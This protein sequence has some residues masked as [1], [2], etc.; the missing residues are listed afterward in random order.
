MQPAAQ[1]RRWRSRPP[2]GYVKPPDGSFT[3]AQLPFAD[4]TAGWYAYRRLDAPLRAFEARRG[5]WLLFSADYPSCRDGQKYFLLARRRMTTWMQ[6]FAAPQRQ[7]HEVIGGAARVDAFPRKVFVDYDA[8]SDGAAAVPFSDALCATLT[9]AQQ[10]WGEHAQHVVVF[11]AAR[12]PNFHAVFYRVFCTG[13]QGPASCE[14]A[15]T[16]LVA[17]MRRCGHAAAAA[18]VD[19][20]LAPKKSMRAPFACKRGGAEEL[21]LFDMPYVLPYLCG[22]KRSVEALQLGLVT[23][24]DG[25]TCRLADACHCSS[26]RVAPRG[27]GGCNASVSYARGN[28]PF[29]RVDAAIAAMLRQMT[30]PGRIRKVTCDGAI[31]TYWVTGNRFCAHVGRQHRSNHVLYVV[32]TAC[33]K[34][35]QRCLDPQCSGYASPPGDVVLG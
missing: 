30:P 32:N 2:P 7:L 14:T 4:G 12:S 33:L 13:M 23:Y 18:N 21:L 9:A 29:P 8:H 34:Y 22:R 17:Q 19:L 5:A 15:L 27:F 24:F 31:V 3:D 6:Y 25:V 35:V 1:K 26:A 11:R 28:S 10:L 16:A 20:T